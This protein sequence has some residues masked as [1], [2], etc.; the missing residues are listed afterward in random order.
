MVE[1]TVRRN[2]EIDRCNHRQSGQPGRYCNDTCES[3]RMTRTECDNLRMKLEMAQ[4]GT[5]DQR[6]ALDTEIG[7]Y[8]S[9]QERINARMNRTVEVRVGLS[10]G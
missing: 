2:R 4:S 3:F 10:R 7:I 1:T 9:E 5:G 8:I 6:T